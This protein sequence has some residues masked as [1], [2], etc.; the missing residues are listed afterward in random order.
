[1]P[2]LEMTAAV[3][4]IKNLTCTSGQ[5]SRVVLWCDCEP[6]VNV[7]NNG[8]GGTEGIAAL[9]HELCEWC[10]SLN[11]YVVARHLSSE[12]NWLA[13]HLSRLRTDEFVRLS[14]YDWSSRV[15]M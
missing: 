8:G 4:A 2:F 3:W 9:M 15:L 1:M 11:V 12:A 6:V 7:I 13:D 10:V 5:Y 14:G